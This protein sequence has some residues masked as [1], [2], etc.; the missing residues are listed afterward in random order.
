[1]T[2]TSSSFEG[3]FRDLFSWLKP[4]VKVHWMDP[5][6][7][8]YEKDERDEADSRVFEVIRIGGNGRVEHDDDIVLISGDSEAEVL[9][10]ELVPCG[11]VRYRKADWPLNQNLLGRR[12][13][14]ACAENDTPS[15]FVPVPAGSAAEYDYIRLRWP[16]SQDWFGEE[17]VLENDH[18]D[19]FVPASVMDNREKNRGVVRRAVKRSLKKFLT[20]PV[21]ARLVWEEID[22]MVADTVCDQIKETLA[23]HEM[24]YIDH[25]CVEPQDSIVVMDGMTL[26]CIRITRTGNIRLTLSGDDY[27]KEIELQEAGVPAL[28]EILDFVLR[29]A[30][31]IDNGELDPDETKG[32]S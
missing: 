11:D 10:F 12:G 3:S 1:M 27:D 29:V 22:K 23:S 16:V 21:K 9:P 25:F 2:Q 14:P 4:G 15:V 13:Y 30:A 28:G 19:V 20:D 8:D 18:G 24:T 17:G 31:R 32:L 5:A 6:I 26:D 7:H